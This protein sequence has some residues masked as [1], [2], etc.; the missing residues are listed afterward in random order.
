MAGFFGIPSGWDKDF[1]F[2]IQF[3]NPRQSKNLDRQTIF[4]RYQKI[5]FGFGLNGRYAFVLFL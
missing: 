2:S 4:S 5:I 3:F 1:S